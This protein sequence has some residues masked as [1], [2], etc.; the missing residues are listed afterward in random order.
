VEL[1]KIS[2]RKIP[3]QYALILHY[4]DGTISGGETELWSYGTFAEA[5]KKI[6]DFERKKLAVRASCGLMEIP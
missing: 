5:E 1:P 4:P 2:I 3:E 6:E